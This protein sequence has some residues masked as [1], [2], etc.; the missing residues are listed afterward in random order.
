MT[1]PA[2]NC[3]STPNEK[4]TTMGTWIDFKELRAT[5]K[6]AEVLK[7]HGVELK[8][9]GDRAT[10]FCP[11]KTHQGKHKSPSFSVQL[12]RNIWQCFG[13]GAKGNALDLFCRLQS[14]DPDDIRQFREAALL[15]EETFAIGGNAD[16]KAKARQR[17]MDTPSNVAEE[18][19]STTAAP[20]TRP[21]VV[22]ATLDF[23]LKK[24]DAH[25]P[26]LTSRGF[27]PETIAHFGLGFCGKGLLAGRV[28]IPLHDDCDNLVGYAGRI[29]GDSL[30]DESHPKYLF[31]SERERNGTVFEFRKS[32]ILY[33]A[34]R[35]RNP[36]DD[37]VVVEG[38]PSTWWLSQCGF[39]HVTAVMGASCSGEQAEL[40]LRAVNPER[41]GLDF[42]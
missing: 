16:G 15:A 37:L 26:Y 22:N 10:G 11:L 6:I 7:H 42:L 17:P 23:T 20:D 5:L 34:N 3:T 25:H 8:V 13:C 9:K 27:T 1:K 2:V 12:A 40:I 41:P 33:N 38:F 18:K 29:V 30:I 39:P 31:P 4:E 14:L 21:R 35:I 24:L 28:A 36:V 19:P 32:L